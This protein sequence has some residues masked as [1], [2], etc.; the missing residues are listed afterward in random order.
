[1]VTWSVSYPVFSLK[2]RCA[3]TGE[4]LNL[5]RIGQD[6]DGQEKNAKVEKRGARPSGNQFIFFAASFIFFNGFFY[7]FRRSC[8]R[9]FSPNG[10]WLI[11][12]FH[13]FLLLF[14]F[15]FVF[16]DHFFF[17]FSLLW[18]SGL[19]SLPRQQTWGFEL[20]SSWVPSLILDLNP[21][22]P[23]LSSPL[24]LGL[25][26]NSDSLWPLIKL[27]FSRGN[28]EQGFWRRVVEPFSTPD[29]CFCPESVNPVVLRFVF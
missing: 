23:L 26:S 27:F 22:R 21:F 7:H 18:G 5:A 16:F 24:P 17:S 10:G 28:G 29:S 11:D 8:R 13:D 3:S 6:P 2:K 15:I 19:T 14:H 12:W 9:G 4:S 25:T 20:A 1:M